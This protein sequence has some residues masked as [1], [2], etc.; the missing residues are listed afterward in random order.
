MTRYFISLCLLAVP[1][2]ASGLTAQQVLEK[3]VSTYSGLKAAHMVAER[4]ETT[5][6]VGQSRTTSAE[7]ELANATGHRYFAR[8]QQPQQQAVSV[9]DGSSIWLI[10]CRTHS[11][12][13][14]RD[15]S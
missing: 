7:C 1:A 8:L 4:E 11:L 6:S 5:Y 12:T 2:S 3:V 13:S 14:T 15:R 10:A 9:S